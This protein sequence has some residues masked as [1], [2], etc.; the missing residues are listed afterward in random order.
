MSDEFDIIQKHGILIINNQELGFGYDSGP[1]RV[2]YNTYLSKVESGG[3]K[4]SVNNQMVVAQL[5]VQ[6]EFVRRA[7]EFDPY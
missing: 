6:A 1:Y 5:A 4:C 3:L 2:L 7:F